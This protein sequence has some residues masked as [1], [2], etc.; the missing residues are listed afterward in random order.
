ME[1]RHGLVSLPQ[2]RE[3]VIQQLTEAFAHDLI[4]VEEL[5]HRLEHVYRAQ[6]AAETEAIVVDL[7]SAAATGSLPSPNPDEPR[8]S[9]DLAPDVPS[10]DRFVAILS[11]SS[12]RGALSVP[13]RLEA[14]AV[15]SDSVIDLTA[16]SLPADI[17]DIHVRIVM[18]NMK[19]VVPAG[20]RVVNR[21]GAFLANV[22]TDSALDLAPM[23][24]GSPVIRITGYATMANLEI[25]AASSGSEHS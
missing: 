21:V 24:P 11:S 13:H 12:R 18:A 15:F 9:R 2:V 5:E 17:V 25:V 23:V 14:L 8:Q 16:A 19:I 20:L 7:R 10:R 6:S 1:S 3:R 22:E 4:S